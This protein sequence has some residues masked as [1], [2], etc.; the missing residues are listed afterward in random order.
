MEYL[1]HKYVELMHHYTLI[2]ITRKLFFISGDV[3]I[4]YLF[5]AGVGKSYCQC[6]RKMPGYQRQSGGFISSHYARLRLQ[7]VTADDL[8]IVLWRLS[9]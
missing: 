4:L 8:V 9:W 2:R 3:I 6:V 1:L 5:N 7:V